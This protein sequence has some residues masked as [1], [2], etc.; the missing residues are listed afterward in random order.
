[1]IN[2]THRQNN[3]LLVSILGAAIAAVAPAV[4]LFGAPNAQAS[5]QC[6][7]EGGIF[8]CVGNRPMTMDFPSWLEECRYRDPQNPNC[9]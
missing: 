6:R 1:M 7:S 8:Y 9:S 3:K 4:M 2:T 5:Q